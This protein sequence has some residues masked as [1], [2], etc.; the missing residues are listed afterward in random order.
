LSRF[1]VFNKSL[2]L[3]IFRGSVE[4]VS[5]DRF[6]HITLDYHS[7]PSVGI[8]RRQLTAKLIHCSL[9]ELPYN[10]SF[11]PRLL[12]W[13]IDV[14][15]LYNHLLLSLDLPELMCGIKNFLQCPLE[16]KDPG[17]IVDWICSLWNFQL[18]PSIENTLQSDPRLSID[19]V[20]PQFNG[21]VKS[22]QQRAEQH[23]YKTLMQ[24]L[25]ACTRLVFLPTC[26]L[27]LEMRGKVMEQLTSRLEGLL[28]TD[29]GGANVDPLSNGKC[30]L[31]AF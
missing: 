8:L 18:A 21:T 2:K 3:S 12:L 6:P 25:L 4:L 16:S 26:P 27:Q 1:L 29:G 28:N 30:E 17:V 7:E 20:S 9:G 24:L 15:L 5:I 14:W 19:I 10:A 23:R 13:S 22:N 31:H 11:L